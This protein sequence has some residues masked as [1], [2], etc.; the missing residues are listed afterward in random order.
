ME[1]SKS[2]QH[3]HAQ[4]RIFAE[5]LNKFENTKEVNEKMQT[6]MSSIK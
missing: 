1:I 4:M 6:Q 5:E 3:H 2:V